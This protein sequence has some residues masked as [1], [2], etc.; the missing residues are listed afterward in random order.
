M[1]SVEFDL[2]KDLE[3]ICPTHCTQHKSEIK[4]LYKEKCIDGGVGGVILI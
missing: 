2:F 3:L 1:G 4:S